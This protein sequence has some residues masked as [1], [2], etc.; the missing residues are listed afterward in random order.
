MVRLRNVV[1]AVLLG[2]G[3]TGC[4]FA[5]WSPFHCD[6]CDDFPA[7]TY[8]P[9]YSMMPGTYTRPSTPGSA[10][11]GAP[12]ISPPPSGAAQPSGGMP[13]MTAPANTTSPPATPAATAPGP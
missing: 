8:G 11:S 2:T 3:L 13:G 7:P 6:S 9:G 10:D 5:H 12:D 4:S 1:M